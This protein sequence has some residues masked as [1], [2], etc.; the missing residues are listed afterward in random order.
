MSGGNIN[1]CTNFAKITAKV[2]VGGI[3]GWG[4]CTDGKGYC[5]VEEC[6]NNGEVI[7]LGPDREYQKYTWNA[8]QRTSVVSADTGSCV[9]GIVGA[10]DRL[11]I[12]NCKNEKNVRSSGSGVGGIVGWIYFSPNRIS[13]KCNK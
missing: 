10:G 8:S 6:K 13:I 11:Q 4:N 7:G 1:K 3:V 12:S 2:V 5:Y 9:G